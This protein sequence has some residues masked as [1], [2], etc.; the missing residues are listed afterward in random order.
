VTTAAIP[1]AASTGFFVSLRENSP[2]PAPDKQRLLHHPT[3]RT[4]AHR[5]RPKVFSRCRSL[6]RAKTPCKGNPWYPSQ[7]GLCRIQ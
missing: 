6:W 4:P 3:A 1:T 7:F 2:G 5:L